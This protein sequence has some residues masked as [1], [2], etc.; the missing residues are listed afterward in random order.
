MQRVLSLPRWFRPAA[1]AASLIFLATYCS[2]SV[3]APDNTVVSVTLTP[4]TATLRVGETTQLTASG[5]NAAGV[6]ITNGVQFASSDA[7]IASVSSDGIVRGLKPGTATITA[8]GGTV[9]KTAVITVT[10]GIAASITKVAGDAQTAQVQTAVTI[11]PSVVVKDSA[12]NNVA[13]A[14][15]TFTVQSGG[16]LVAGSTVTT[17]AAG[18]ATLGAW[19]LGAQVGANSVVATV[20]P[21]VTPLSVTFLANA[22]PRVAGPPA[23][24]IINAGDAQTGIIGTA[25]AVAPSVLVRDAVG[26]VVPNAAVTFAVATGGGTLTGAPVFTNV[27]GVATIG[28][29]VLGP[30][31]GTQSITATAGALPPV[32]FTATATPVPQPPAS[33]AVTVA[34]GGAIAGVPFG[35]Q[36][37]VEIRDIGGNLAFQATNTVTANISFGGRLTGTFT[38]DAV[39]GIATFTDLTPLDLGNYV[40]NFTSPGLI[41][42]TTNVLVTTG[43]VIALGTPTQFAAVATGADPASQTIAITNSGSGGVITGLSIAPIDYQGPPGPAWL[44]ASLSAGAT[45]STVILQ[46]HTAGLQ[47]GTYSAIV[48]VNGTG[49]TPASVTVSFVVA[50]QVPAQIGI[51]TQPNGGTST[52]PIATQPVV[53]VRDAAGQRVLGSTMVVGVSVASGPGTISGPTQVQAINGVVTFAGLRLTTPGTYSLVFGA[54]GLAPATSVTFTVTP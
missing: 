53:E 33:L 7:A 3:T 30:T 39:G 52:T 41:G 25:V 2:D 35:V 19:V 8:T 14:V 9:Q 32:T 50:A 31:V 26:L 43:A 10:P 16:G 47:P 13:G 21:S 27:S 36:P 22:T 4:T 6:P 40:I 38:V 46:P 34:P 29:W 1:A 17:N 37:V 23:S 24:I 44:T 54:A 5:S 12:G 49:A 42:A 51:L 48:T 45:P 20:L 18:V 11:A 28:S 15:V